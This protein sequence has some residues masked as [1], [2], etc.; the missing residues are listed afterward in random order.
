MNKHSLRVMLL[1]ILLSSVGQPVLARPITVDFSFHDYTYGIDVEGYV[2]GLED[3]G[4]GQAATSV[5]VTSN[6]GGYGLGEYVGYPTAN[7]WD[8]FDGLVYYAEFRSNGVLNTSPDVTC[9]ALGLA[10]FFGTGTGYQ[11]GWLHNDPSE[12]S[13]VGVQN[14]VTFTTRRPA[15]SIPVMP[16]TAL[17]LLTLALAAL[18][19]YRRPRL[20]K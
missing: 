18:G 3:N 12:P 13:S 4:S 19:V 16:F 5:F 7:S 9:C 2:L 8:V 6:S 1:T 10:E 17:A 15:S 20:L 14:G 11:I